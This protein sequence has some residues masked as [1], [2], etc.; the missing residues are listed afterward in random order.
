MSLGDLRA[1]LDVGP[2][3]F[4]EFSFT[5]QHWWYC[6]DARLGLSVRFSR[7][8]AFCLVCVLGLVWCRS[9]PPPLLARLGCLNPGDAA[10]AGGYNRLLL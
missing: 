6:D 4:T 7:V 9:F 3:F 2:F 10:F 8:V 5:L 1:L